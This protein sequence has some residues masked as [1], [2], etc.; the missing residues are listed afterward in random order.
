[1]PDPLRVVFAGT[2]DF[3]AQALRSL[4]D[5]EVCEVVA[6]YSQPDRPK[7]RGKKLTPS[8][9][10]ALALEQH[11]PVFQPLDFKHVD[12]VDQLARLKPDVMVVAAYGLLLPTTVLNVPRLGC[13]NIHASL[14]P[15]WRGAAPIERAI[16]EGEEVTGVTIMQMDKG[17]DTGAMLLKRQTEIT[18]QDTGDT[19][20]ARLAALGGEAI[21]E[22]LRQCSIA[23][24]HGEAQ[25]TNAATYA[26]K[27]LKQECLIDWSQP[28]QRIAQKMRAFYSGYTTHSFLHGERIKF[29]AA[30]AEQSQQPSAPG[31]IVGTSK[32]TLHIGS[33]DGIVVVKQLQWPGGRMLNASDLLN[34][35]ADKLQVGFQF[36]DQ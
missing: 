16:E 23:P 36:F 8:P 28:A 31:K 26:A 5:A 29:G 20:R 27:I 17:L 24:V 15:A 13:I 2:P 14:L 18:V 19:V 12:D 3:A 25:D 7:G 11:L 9:V 4:L 32:S 34:S 6:V 21:N 1:M 22:V 35:R 30:Y 33:G 10:K